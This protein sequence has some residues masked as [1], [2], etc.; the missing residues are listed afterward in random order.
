MVMVALEHSKVHIYWLKNDG[1]DKIYGV[2]YWI[3]QNT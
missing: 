1:N 3:F 2:T